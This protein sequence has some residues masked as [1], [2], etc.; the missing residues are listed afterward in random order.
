MIIIMLAA[1]MTLAM[2]IATAF[3][4]HQEAQ[5]VRVENRQQKIN[6]YRY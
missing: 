5:R 6:R 4:L 3:G 1:T 2:L